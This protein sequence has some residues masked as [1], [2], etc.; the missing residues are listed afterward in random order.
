M[1]QE[2][3]R[4]ASGYAARQEVTVRPRRGGRIVRLLLLSLLSQFAT[5]ALALPALVPGEIP[6]IVKVYGIGSTG[7]MSNVPYRAIARP[8]TRSA[9]T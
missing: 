8:T 5:A 4:F 2:R 6:P 3:H 9:G 1:E 7:W